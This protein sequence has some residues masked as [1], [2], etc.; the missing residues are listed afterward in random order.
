MLYESKQRVVEYYVS[1]QEIRFIAWG[2]KSDPRFL[3]P[4]SAALLHYYPQCSWLVFSL[5]AGGADHI[6]TTVSPLFPYGSVPYISQPCQPQGGAKPQWTTSWGNVLPD[7]RMWRAS[8]LPLAL[9]VQHWRGG[10]KGC[11]LALRRAGGMRLWLMWECS[12]VRTC[13][14]YHELS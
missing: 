5:T 14:L 8:M 3:P 9:R 10:A 2:H 1:K 13:P 7:L 4:T 6:R 12:E 11:R